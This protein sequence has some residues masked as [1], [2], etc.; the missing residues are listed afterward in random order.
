MLTRPRSKRPRAGSSDATLLGPPALE[1]ERSRAR[2]GEQW[3]RTL[4]VV[5]YPREVTRGWLE[6]LLRAAGEL[7]LSLHVEPVAPVIAADRLRR[8]R[9]RLESTRRL[10]RER[11]QLTDPT[12]AQGARPGRVSVARDAA[13]RGHREAGR[14]SSSFCRSGRRAFSH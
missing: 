2:V 14:S 9:A 4:A 5:G 7:D 11:G 10:E 1:L 6:P 8:Q 12:V 3:L 13:R